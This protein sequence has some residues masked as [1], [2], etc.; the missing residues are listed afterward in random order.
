MVI[1]VIDQFD[2]EPTKAEHQS[3]TRRDTY[4]PVAAI[5]PAQGV[6]AISGQPH[7]PRQTGLIQLQKQTPQSS[8]MIGTDSGNVAPLIERLQAF[9]P[10]ADDHATTV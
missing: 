7:V 9:M 1:K 8:H 6:Q 10:E 5:A 2:V 4:R 3:P